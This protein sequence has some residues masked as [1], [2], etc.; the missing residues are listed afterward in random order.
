M[1]AIPTVNP[2]TRR[3]HDPRRRG[4]RAV[5][6]VHPLIAALAVLLGLS[7]AAIGRQEQVSVHVNA[8]NSAYVGD[9]F[10]LQVIVRG[11]REAPR[12][13]VPVTPDYTVEYLGP[14]DASTFS[15]TFIN[16]QFVQQTSIV[17]THKFAIRA[18]RA[19][20]ITIPPF[21]VTVD[22]R[23]YPTRPVTIKVQEPAQSD[24]FSLEITPEKSRIYQ[25]EP[26]RVRFVWSF[27]RQPSG[28]S[29]QFPP[30]PPGAEYLPAPDPRPPGTRP[31]DSRFQQF[32]LDGEPIVATVSIGNRAGNRVGTFSFERILI[33]R[34]VPAGG[35]LR[36]G[37]G[38]I[39]F[40]AVIGQRAPRFTDGPF[41]DLNVYER[42][43][44]VSRP[45]EIQVLPLPEAGR[46]TDFSGLVGAYS[47]TASAEPREVSVGEPFTL[48]ITV[49]GPPP[50]SL[51]PILD[52]AD[53][54]SLT[55]A[56]RVPRDPVLPVFTPVGA[57]F[58]YAVR[59]RSP[60]STQIPP[61]SLN[62]FDTAAG[63][64]R[65]A[66][67]E[68]IRLSVR[69]SSAAGADEPGPDDLDAEA[70]STTAAARPSARVD[71]TSLQLTGP[72]AAPLLTAPIIA[73]AALVPPLCLAIAWAG[74]SLRRRALA[75]PAAR[76]RR[77]ALR[78]ARRRLRRVAATTH[79]RDAAAAVS[80]VLTHLAA[81]WF[82]RPPG[83]LTSAEALALLGGE[84]AR[85]SRELAGLLAECDRLRFST[86]EPAPASPASLFDRARAVLEQTS[87]ALR[88]RPCT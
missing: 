73:V 77:R 28:A 86:P 66:R 33:V 65:V 62:Y 56:F 72:P 61:I 69:P 16:G 40:N 84:D 74:V 23:V 63:E 82:D 37:P 21:D 64:Y 55:S 15:A 13:D 27:G 51:I 9:A 87:A 31:E 59:A 4:W 5:C 20:S 24:D 7:H 52:L 50:L 10:E 39:D 88:S 18:R 44:C 70:A 34:E 26:V 6:G 78:S 1:I 81:D 3:T 58:T 68:P 47:V 38:R 48:R 2:S 71:T 75:H 80:A 19:G 41:A 8:P 17:F 29:F 12:P 45:F 14:S 35:V 30:L 32:T 83:S 76:R 79:P 53:Q 57:M 25:G 43:A 49:N 46:P 42:H 67:S 22:G 36:F 60:E 54:P 85:D 11:S